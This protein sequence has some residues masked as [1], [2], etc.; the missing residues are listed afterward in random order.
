MILDKEVYSGKYEEILQSIDYSVGVLEKLS[1]KLESQ[2]EK[3]IS[4]IE[5]G[6][7]P[8]IDEI[9]N[10]DESALSS[11]NGMITKLRKFEIVV[12]DKLKKEESLLIQTKKDDSQTDMQKLIDMQLEF[13]KDFIKSSKPDPLP[14][15]SSV[16]RPKLELCSFNGDKLKW[17]EFW[18]SF[19]TSVH[20]KRQSF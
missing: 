9:L 8:L 19:E 14:V 2:S 16:K 12:K 10:G 5:D 7:D 17:V 18:Q 11:A 13:Q 15:K 20:K 6:E 3:L 1:N 4:A